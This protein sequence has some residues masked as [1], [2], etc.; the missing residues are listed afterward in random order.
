MQRDKYYAAQK[1]VPGVNKVITKQ[2]PADK[3]VSLNQNLNS[4]T[5]SQAAAP[6]AAPPIPP[7]FSLLCP[8]SLPRCSTRDSSHQA[9]IN[10]KAL[11][12]WQDALSVQFDAANKALLA[13]TTLKTLVPVVVQDVETHREDY[14]IKCT[15]TGFMSEHFLRVGQKY[16]D[17]MFKCIAIASDLFQKGV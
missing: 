13:A 17:T 3:N 1:K 14:I 11:G 16:M 4:N 9:A 10:N 15:E 5:L 2:P 12:Y 7:P 6:L 8:C